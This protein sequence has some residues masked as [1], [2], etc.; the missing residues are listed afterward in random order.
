MCPSLRELKIG[1][2]DS[3]FREL[4]LLE[5][6]EF[7]PE[8]SQRHLAA[9]LGI[10][11]G[12]ANLLVRNLARKGYIRATRAGWKQW[13][14]NLTPAGV[15]R[16][17]KLTLAYVDRVLE[18]YQCVRQILIDGMGDMELEPNS[19]VAIYGAGEMGELMYLVLREIGVTQVDF[20]DEDEGRAFLGT[21][22]RDLR[23]I[24]SAEYVKVMVA[25]SSRIPK[26]CADL[27]ATGVAES[28]IITFLRTPEA[29]EGL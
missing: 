3:S 19:R 6:V 26:R 11:L 18:H 12:V 24:E 17:T 1:L 28:Q 8:T 4:R 7:E 23:T 22:V 14:Y 10:A 21:T 27:R 29:V 13:A 9:R 15:G 25:F 20:F 2:E 5:E 16:K